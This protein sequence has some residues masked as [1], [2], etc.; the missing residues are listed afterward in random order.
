MKTKLTRL[1]AQLCRELG[2]PR[3]QISI[4]KRCYREGWKGACGL[5]LVK[6]KT[7]IIYADNCDDVDYDV[8]KVLAHET[9]HHFQN[10]HGWMGDDGRGWL[11]KPQADYVHLE[12]SQR[13]WEEQAEHYEKYISLREGWEKE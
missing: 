7:I 6:K 10:C 2:I 3:A 8:R 5:Y 1:H 11:G 12:H 9:L 13:P 4:R